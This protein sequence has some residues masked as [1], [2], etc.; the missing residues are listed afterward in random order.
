[1]TKRRTSTKPNLRPLPLADL[2]HAQGGADKTLD[3][4]KVELKD[5]IITSVG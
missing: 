3:Y 4:L 5:I 2:R 1:M